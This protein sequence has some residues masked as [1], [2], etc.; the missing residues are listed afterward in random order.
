MSAFGR[1]SLRR[2]AFLTVVFVWST[3]LGVPVVAGPAG[4]ST[5][6]C[7]AKATESEAVAMAERAVAL[8]PNDAGCR[9]VLGYVLAYEHRWP[10]SEAELAA[11]LQLD[12]NNA[13]AWAISTDI[14]VF[15]G[16]PI[17]AIEQA[18][19]AL[20]LNPYPAGWYYRVLGLAQYAA[21]QYAAAVATL[22]HQATYRTASRRILAA[23]LAQLGRLDEARQ[24]AA[25]FM[26]SN[27]HFTINHW[28]SFQPFRDEPTREHFIE[29]YRKAGLPE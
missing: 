15:C 27:P 3:A 11:A 5:A 19:K 2:C 1:K 23:S 18:Q 4:A 10:E 29:G 26:S 20:R 24:E 8:D 25:L 21:H 17:S 7:L 13:D 28:I 14:S 6:Q 22:R 12:P 16:N 9:W